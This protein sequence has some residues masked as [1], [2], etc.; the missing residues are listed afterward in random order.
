MLQPFLISWAR[1]SVGRAPQWHCGGRQFDPD[2]VHHF[3]FRIGK[4]NVSP[5][6]SRRRRT[7]QTARQPR[8]GR[9]RRP[10]PHSGP[11]NDGEWRLLQGNPR[12]TGRETRR[13]L[14]TRCVHNLG[15]FWKR[16]FRCYFDWRLFLGKHEWCP[17]SLWLHPSKDRS[18]RWADFRRMSRPR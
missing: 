4:K 15:T 1:S 16:C 11:S 5:K 8:R 17:E 3:S 18:R 13:L 9:R 6:P 2:R 14:V 7:S 12:A 10:L